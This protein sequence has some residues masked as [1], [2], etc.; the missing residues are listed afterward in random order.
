MSRCQIFC[1]SLGE[2]MLNNGASDLVINPHLQKKTSNCLK[3]RRH[4][5]IDNQPKGQRKWPYIFNSI[6]KMAWLCNTGWVICY[7][8][9]KQHSVCQS[10]SCDPPWRGGE[11][12]CAL[13]KALLD[14]GSIRWQVASG[15]NHTNCAQSGG[16]PHGTER[17]PHCDK[18]QLFSDTRL[19]SVLHPKLCRTVLCWWTGR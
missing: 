14:R 7:I 11:R 19:V 9:G 15:W 3:T 8:K 16:K 5:Q 2:L 18:E 13:M 1:V 10:K 6:W 17:A 4:L 12:T